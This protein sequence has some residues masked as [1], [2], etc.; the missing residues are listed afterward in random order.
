VWQ[1]ATG[2]HSDCKGLVPAAV[3]VVLLGMFVADLANCIMTVEK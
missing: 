2:K 3:P 1:V